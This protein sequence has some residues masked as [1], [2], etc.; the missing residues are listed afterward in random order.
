MLTDEQIAELEAKHGRIG[1]L[2]HPDGETWGVVL[3]KPTGAELKIF[4][5]D[6]GD[7]RKKDDAQEA[8]FRRLCVYPDPP[9]LQALLDEWPGIA[10]GPTASKVLQ[11]LA[12]LESVERGK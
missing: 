3:R 2:T 5:R 1:V 6:A 10:D 11:S 8:F 4:R 9:G 7:A 12:G